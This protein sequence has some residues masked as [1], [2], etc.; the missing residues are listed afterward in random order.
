MDRPLFSY[1]FDG[2]KL[3]SRAAV[4][5]IGCQSAGGLL[6]V[7]DN[8]PHCGQL[9]GIDRND[10]CFE[11]PE[12][13]SRQA[14]SLLVMDASKPFDF[15]DNSFDLVLHKDTLEC[16]ADIPAIVSE[17]HRVLKPGG[18]VIC[19]NCDW[20]S[21]IVNGS[22]K[23]LI[24]KAVSGYANFRQENWMDAHDGWIGRRIWGHF[25]KGKLFDGYVKLYAHIETDFDEQ[26]I[27]WH[28]I[29]EMKRYQDPA[30]FLTSEEHA[31]L[32]SDIKATYESGEYLFV[33]PA[34]IYVGR[35]RSLSYHNLY[36]E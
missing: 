14:I 35:K 21:I 9:T 22:N 32:V 27:G 20:E 15:D 19:I 2:V 34:F 3:P 11:S 26:N 13:L 17:M 31:E 5:D 18:T 16:F 6:W 7:R 12:A 36:R 4:L 25:N 24:N 33:W 10:A 29:H 23:A 28:Y 8:Y 1:A 30:P